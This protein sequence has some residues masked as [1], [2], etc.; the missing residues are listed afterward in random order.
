LP[1]LGHSELVPAAICKNLASNPTLCHN[2]DSLPHRA[3]SNLYGSEVPPGNWLRHSADVDRG[4]LSR[5]QGLASP[6]LD[7]VLA[8]HNQIGRTTIALQAQT[9]DGDWAGEAQ[10]ECAI[11]SGLLKLVAECW[12]GSLNLIYNMLL[13]LIVH[14]RVLRPWKGE[15]VCS[16]I[17]FCPRRKA[18]RVYTCACCRCSTPASVRPV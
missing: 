3:V 13:C 6:D 16:G 9:E 10:A 15:A 4:S 8:I 1:L 12:P 5:G 18:A 7:V 11:L 2:P 14:L 17:L